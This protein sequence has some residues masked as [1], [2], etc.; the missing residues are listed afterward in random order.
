MT[1][2]KRAKLIAV[3]CMM[4]WLGFPGHLSAATLC[5]DLSGKFMIQGEDGQVHITIDQRGCT[6]IGIVRTYGYLG[7]K[8]TD[9]HTL[10]LNGNE[11]K[12]A[13]WF[14]EGDREYRTSA[15]FIGSQLQIRVRLLDGKI[16]HVLFWLNP[17]QDLLESVNGESPSLAL[18][19]K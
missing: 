1:I 11:Q 17:E 4:I 7:E 16:F 9:K 10:R 18:R 15:R 19:E 14:G 6:R 8:T 5:P 12:D 3:S 13:K 2:L